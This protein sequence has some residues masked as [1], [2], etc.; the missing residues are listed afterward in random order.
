[1]AHVIHRPRMQFNPQ[2]PPFTDGYS[3]MVEKQTNSSVDGKLQREKG[4]EERG[5]RDQGRDF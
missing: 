4:K 3:W 2:K 1:M 5:N